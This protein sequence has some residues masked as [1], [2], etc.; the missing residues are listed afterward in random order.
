MIDSFDVHPFRTQLP[1]RLFVEQE[2]EVLNVPA[3]ET[4]Q[5]VC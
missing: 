4:E 5:A 3:G 2:L 1:T